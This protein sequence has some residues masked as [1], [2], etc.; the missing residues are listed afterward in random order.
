MSLSQD[1]WLALR[2]SRI[3]SGLS[4]DHLR[5]LVRVMKRRTLQSGEALFK[6]GWTGDFMAVVAAGAFRVSVMNADGRETPVTEL[7][8]GD[9]MG[10]MACVDPAPRS[11]TVTALAPAVVYCLSRA[12]LIAFRDKGPEVA[13]AIVGGVI[14]QVTDRIRKTNARIEERMGGGAAPA[15]RD[16]AAAI[17]EVLGPAAIRPPALHR[18]SVD[19]SRVGDLGEL[20]P[21][22]LEVLATVSRR[23]RYAAGA[24]LCAE[25]EAAESCYVVVEGEVEVIKQV[26]DS[27]RTL[28]TLSGCLLGQMALVDPGPRSATLLARTPVVAL[29]LGRDTFEQLLGQ[30]SPFVMRFQDMLAVAGIRQLRQANVKLA[31]IPARTTAFRADKPA[32]SR[33]TA[34]KIGAESPSHRQ[35]SGHTAESP[36]HKRAKPLPRLKRRVPPGGHPLPQ[37]LNPSSETEALSVTLA[38]MQASLNDWG[39]SMDDLDAI[40]V[41]RCEGV[42][43]VS[44]RNARLRGEL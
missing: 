34:P 3:L 17:R 39:M 20:T 8:A 41:H 23:L 21:A 7:A 19:L 43:S 33:S 10:E 28:S 36:S 29:E 26:G 31:A 38:Y 22:D 25:G 9:V 24:L 42:M 5:G 44:E 6:Q 18:E 32:P 12:M 30:H 27:P 15:C 13:M 16:P 1:I 4:E 2:R 14:G 35:Q 11:A 40:S 37:A